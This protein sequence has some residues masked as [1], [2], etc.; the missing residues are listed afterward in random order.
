MA[1]K[2]KQVAEVQPAKDLPFLNVADLTFS[3]R[4]SRV[5]V[6]EAND[7]KN[8]WG[9]M[10]LV[11]SDSDNRSKKRSKAVVEAKD[12]EGRFTWFEL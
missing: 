10:F 5:A 12:K 1:S 11:Y 6:I 8:N 9:Y 2:G 7:K 4:N 3:K